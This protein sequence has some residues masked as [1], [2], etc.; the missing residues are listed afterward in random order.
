MTPT[1]ITN[2]SPYATR[3]VLKYGFGKAA[4]SESV[5]L[6]M[7]AC[8]RSNRSIRDTKKPGMTMSPKPNRENCPFSSRVGKMRGKRSLMGPSNDFATV[9]YRVCYRVL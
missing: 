8:T 1:V 3:V 5:V 6:G 4:I 2:P 9:T 7:A